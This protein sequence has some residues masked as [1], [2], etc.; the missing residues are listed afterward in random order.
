MQMETPYPTVYR[1]TPAPT[2]RQKKEK[3]M[4]DKKAKNMKKDKKKL[5]KKDEKDGKTTGKL[6]KGTKKRMLLRID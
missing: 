5:D 6:M 2:L 3:D 4:K 1:S